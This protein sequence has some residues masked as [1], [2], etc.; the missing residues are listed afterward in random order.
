[1]FRLNIFIVERIKMQINVAGIPKA[2]LLQA[3]YN[4][5]PAAALTGKMTFEQAESMVSRTLDFDYIG[6]CCIK[7]DL[8]GDVIDTWLYDRDNGQ[9]AAYKAL[10]TLLGDEPLVI[11]DK[12]YG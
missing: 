1:M 5:C 8:S 4:N 2:S 9:F 3:L 10:K 12:Q 6:V 11:N 7:T